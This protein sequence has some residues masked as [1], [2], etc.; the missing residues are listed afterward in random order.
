M[1]TSG[2]GG[3]PER[4]PERHRT[5]GR[6]GPSVAAEPAAPAW[7]RHWTVR[8]AP[9]NPLAAADRSVPSDVPAADLSVYCT[10]LGDDALV[11]ARRQTGW[12]QHSP[13]LEEDCAQVGILLELLGQA[14][15]LLRRAAAVEGSGRD[16]NLLAHARGVE[17]FRNARLVEIDCG[18]G[19]GG[20]FAVSI[21]RLM[22]CAAWRTAL[23]GRL[24]A[25]RDPVLSELA[26][27][28]LP[29]VRGHRDH[30]AQW[31][32]R[33]GDGTPA[34]RE[35]MSVGLARVWPMTGE[36]FAPHPVESRLAAL[37]YAVDP[38]GLRPEV[39]RLL[40]EVLSVARLEPPDSRV[41]H[42]TAEPLGRGGTHTSALEFLLAEMRQ[43]EPVD[44]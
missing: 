1:V 34:S 38:T 7:E 35:R 10:M 3:T 8:A 25:S 9:G 14:R 12:C 19:S 18:P 4:F 40:D 36:L 22:V 21:A 16:E 20:D 2:A 17:E 43:Y 41:F 13:D 33:L 32:I 44:T 37:G 5:S 42:E 23:F 24:V 27:V 31:V 28:A 15:E 39:S 11:L 26:R 29:E 6:S 30:A